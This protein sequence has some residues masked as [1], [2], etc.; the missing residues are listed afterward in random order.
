MIELQGIDR[1]YKRSGRIK[2]SALDG[3]DLTINEGDFLAITGPSG[4][5]KTTL[6]NIIGGVDRPS[7][8][9]VHIQGRDIYNL[10]SPEISHFRNQTIGYMHQFYCLPPH[11]TVVEQV[12]LP[13]LIAGKKPRAARRRSLELLENLGVESL[14]HSYPH[15]LSGGQAQRVALAR[16]LACSPKI[17]L[18][19]EPTGNLDDE[20]AISL[21]ET[22]G[23]INKE[24]GV[25]TIVVTHDYALIEKADRVVTIKDG[26]LVADTK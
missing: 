5:G 11:L 10:S 13:L 19:D 18:A 17:L 25:T 22:L 23:K 24:D 16:A 15:Q 14:A 8:G 3:L 26:N 4:A 21:I 7:S 12:M 9:M 1:L 20:T 6:L 2:L